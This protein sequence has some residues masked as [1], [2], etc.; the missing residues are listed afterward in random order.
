M[1]PDRIDRIPSITDQHQPTWP[2]SSSEGCNSPPCCLVLMRIMIPRSLCHGTERR[3][4]AWILTDWRGFLVF[5]STN[6]RGV[7][8]WRAQTGRSVAFS[9][10]RTILS[11]LPGSPSTMCLERMRAGKFRL[12]VHFACSKSSARSR[13]FMM[14]LSVASLLRIEV[15][16][17]LLLYPLYPV[18]FL[19]P[20]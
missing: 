8:K 14:A 12:C 17:R 3:T 10:D 9:R 7:D 1:R 19:S 5:P 18:E 4:I 11:R 15:H 16:R 13:V 6:V 20:P 2:L